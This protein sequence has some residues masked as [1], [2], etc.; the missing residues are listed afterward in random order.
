M[1]G[2]YWYQESRVTHIVPEPLVQQI[3]TAIENYRHTTNESPKHIIVYRGG[4][5]EG[6]F[7]AV[8]PIRRLT[9]PNSSAEQ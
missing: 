3:A 9:F 6:E 1:R 8:S 4:V 2:T 7:A 5:S